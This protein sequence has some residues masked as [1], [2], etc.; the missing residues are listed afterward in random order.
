MPAYCFKC[1]SCGNSE[2]IT[3]TMDKSDM[4][5]A[6][7]KCGKGMT[8][9][10]PAEAPGRRARCDTYPFASDALGGH[11]DDRAALTQEAIAFGVPT[12][13]NS[14]G[15]PIMRSASHRKKYCNAL[16]IHDRNAGYSDPTPV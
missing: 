16:K 10:Y 12:E 3:R 13:I 15:N 2:S 4:P 11:P 7:S 8:R 14:A 5:L 6:C 9:D 1:E